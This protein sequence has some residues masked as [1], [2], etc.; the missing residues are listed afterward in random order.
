MPATPANAI[1]V[2]TSGAVSFNGTAFTGGTLSVPNG[3]TGAVTLSSSGVLVGNGTSPIAAS[4]SPTVT[5]ITITGTPSANTDGTNV[6]Y[7]QN[8]IATVNPGTSVFAATTINIPGTYT[9]VGSG[10]GDTFLTTATGSFTLDGT[11]PAVGARILFK[12]QTTTFQNGVYTLTTN[13]TGI[14]G[15][16]FTRA[17]DYDQ[18]S[19]INSTGVI[20]V[21]NGTV[22]Q[23][24]GWLLNVTVTSVG[25]SP[26]TYV[27]FNS[28][29]I[30][31][32]VSVANGGTGAATLTAHNVL[33]GEGTSTLGFS[34]PSS[35][36]GVPLISQGASSDPVFG[37]AV[38]AGGGTGVTSTT[39]YA[40]LCGG[41]TATAPI[42][43][44]ASVGTTGQVLTSNGAAALPTFQT[45]A[46]SGFTT[47]V[48]QT[49]TS[50]GT[51]TP[52]ANM[53]YCIVQ[54]LGGGGAGG[55][56]TATA[57]NSFSVGGGGGSGE[58]AVGVFSAATI[59]ASQAVTIGAA[60]AANSGATGGNGGN[61][62]I[63]ALM[64]ANGGSG[65]VT[66]AAFTT[67]GTGVGGAGGT[68][69]SGGSF[70]TP[71]QHGGFGFGFVTTNAVPMS[72]NGGNT[73]IGAG[74]F[75][76]AGN[77]GGNAGLG[78][79]SGGAGLSNSVSQSAGAGGAGTAGIVIVTEY[80]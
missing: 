78:Y 71:G 70:R 12:N 76:A 65:G 61:T 48:I 58:Y 72:G 32:P 59:G 16:L 38:V 23:L 5:S 46:S 39:A 18:P 20:A 47:V 66:V 62:S 14:T 3:G 37:T 11:S 51:Y 26:I 79:G 4:T 22:N 74:G 56:A 64:S 19:D 1:N 25:S 10:I 36:S 69:G 43:S 73:Q 29:P 75:G 77:G 2:S 80:I 45:A 15:T 68:G 67:N 31:Y 33:L 41:T 50:T 54:C 60:G 52:T 30:S 13:G 24:T 9:P 42:Q 21:V 44:I 49:F 57:S 63:G 17:I 6:L 34:A 28:A 35:T 40:V 53:K 27:L 7:V 8:A 55:G